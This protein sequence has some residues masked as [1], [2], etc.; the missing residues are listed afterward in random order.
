MGIKHPWKVGKLAG[1]LCLVETIYNRKIKTHKVVGTG[2]VWK[3]ISLTNA[4]WVSQSVS[5]L[6]S[7]KCC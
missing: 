5:V 2:C 7:F 3:G 4:C 1:T 6:L